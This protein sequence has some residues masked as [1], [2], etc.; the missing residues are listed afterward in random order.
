MEVPLRGGGEVGVK[1]LP[2]RRKEK[3]CLQP[4]N[5][6]EQNYTNIFFSGKRS[7]YEFGLGKREPYAFGLGR[8]QTNMLCGIQ[9]VAGAHMR[10]HRPEPR[11]IGCSYFSNQLVFTIV[12]LY[13]TVLQCTEVYCSVLQ[14][15]SWCLHCPA[16]DNTN[17]KSR[18]NNGFI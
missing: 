9:N 6:L 1:G 2:L 4:M 18:T 10:K 3:I 15:T 5:A 16:A 14:C 8:R 11:N 7:P 13:S 12:L 17:K